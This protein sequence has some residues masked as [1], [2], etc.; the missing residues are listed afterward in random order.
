MGLEGAE[1]LTFLA[2]RFA[3]VAAI[4]IPAALLFG[5]HFPRNPRL[6]LHIAITG[7]VMQ[8]IYF[9]TSY[10]AF[11][12]GGSAG[13]VALILGMQPVVTACIVGPLLGERVSGRQWLGLALGFAGVVLVLAE[14]LGAGVGT[15][16]GVAWTCA[17]LTAITLGT[18]YQKRYCP[19]FDLLAGG[20]IQ[21]TVAALAVGLFAVFLEDM[22]VHWSTR[23]AWALAY[24][25][26]INSIVAIGLL[27]WMIRRGEASRVTALFFLVPPGAALVAWLVLGESLTQTGLLGMAIAAVGVMLVM[28]R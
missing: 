7:L 12:A 26:L 19:S 10:I 14:K 20:A 17:S 23:F 8:A 22:T 27:T 16:A 2:L 3:I 6:I 21:F 25:V 5:S 18:L 11:D 1:P 28:R 13:G 24:L 15:P 4:L 9:G